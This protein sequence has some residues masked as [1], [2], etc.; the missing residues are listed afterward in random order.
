M[1]S[2]IPPDP[3]QA[4]SVSKD[5]DISA[6]RTAYRKLVLKY[7]PDRI[8]DPALKER[9]KSEFQKIQHAYELLSE[10][11]RRSRYD[12]SI[13]LAEL[14][15]EAMMRDPTPRHAY[16][17][18]PTPP[19]AA[20][21][22]WNSD[23]QAFY[24]V[25]KPRETFFDGK[26]RFDETPRTMSR[27]HA[28]YERST[29]SKKSAAGVGRAEKSKASSML[30]AA[31]AAVNGGIKI[32]HDPERKKDSRTY[33]KE[34][35]QRSRDKAKARQEKAEQSRRAFVSEDSDS[36]TVSRVTSSTIR[37]SYFQ[38][39]RQSREAEARP[40]PGH[41]RSH[42]YPDYDSE[43]DSCADKWQG[44]HSNSLR[45]IQ[46]KATEA[47]YRRP[48]NF[49]Q[50]SGSYWNGRKN[51]TGDIR[52]GESPRARQDEPPARPSMPTHSSA[53]SN[54]KPYVEERTPKEPRKSTG[55]YPMR[56]RA[57]DFD[58]RKEM[59]S[60]PSIHR[61]QTMPTPKSSSK[62][63]SV[64]SK[65]SNLKH[66]ETHDSGYGSSSSPHTPEMREQSPSW[67]PKETKTMYHVFGLASDD[68]D[69]TTQVRRV[70]S[71]PDRRPRLAHTPDIYTRECRRE[72]SDKSS[73]R[74]KMK[75][76]TRPST[77]KDDYTK[78]HRS[79]SSRYDSHSPR[80]AAPP[81]SRHSSARERLPSE[82][83]DSDRDRE[84]E[85]EIPRYKI[86][87][88]KMFFC[89]PHQ[90]AQFS[91]Y[92]ESPDRR[93]HDQAPG[94]RFQESVRYPYSRRPSVY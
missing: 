34:Q 66:A 92:R 58:H 76:A 13:K 25:R 93:G 38:P 35:E 83:A 77:A 59:G 57:R 78:T 9:G 3:Y 48:H 15:K 4:L 67:R 79:E 5:A 71:D 51:S 22:E 91:N 24:E 84:R 23:D 6:I 39:G 42:S 50:S 1:S 44:H 54:L 12:D 8:Q 65:S 18:R 62:K 64:P 63:D 49:R 41:Q 19:A 89:A 16:P 87:P 55:S 17:P 33:S 30:G 32:K 81:L 26:D 11:M 10:P 73:A 46:K 70:D 56:E 53:P 88:E 47:G 37:P 31:F 85:R 75:S 80:E 61:A 68:D 86:A 90:E 29:A 94:S 52:Y 36:D 69:R 20:S 2:P 45:Y 82:V 72:K 27:K 43:G 60:P 40:S 21:R 14:R 28:E 74:P 7:H